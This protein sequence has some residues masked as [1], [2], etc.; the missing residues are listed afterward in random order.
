MCFVSA[1]A[2]LACVA[3]NRIRR[4]MDS[5]CAYSQE[6]HLKFVELDHSMLKKR[7][8]PVP[9]CRSYRNPQ[10]GRGSS[11]RRKRALADEELS[12][13]QSC[14]DAHER[15]LSY[16]NFSKRSP[17]RFAR[18]S[19]G[20]VHIAQPGHPL[21]D[22]K[23]ALRLRPS[24]L[25]LWLA[26][27]TTKITTVT[28]TTTT[29]QQV[30][31]TAARISRWLRRELKSRMA[32]GLPPIVPKKLDFSAYTQTTT[33]APKVL[34]HLSKKGHSTFIPR[35]LNFG[36][37]DCP[38]G[39]GQQDPHG[40]FL[41]SGAADKD[42][43]VQ[44]SEEYY[45]YE[46]STPTRCS[47]I[48]PMKEDESSASSPKRPSYSWHQ[49]KDEVKDENTSAEMARERERG[50]GASRGRG[51]LPVR[52]L[53]R[54]AEGLPAPNKQNAKVARWGHRY[55]VVTTTS[56]VVRSIS[57]LALF[58]FFAGSGIALAALRS[59]SG[60]CRNHQDTYLALW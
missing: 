41:R 48:S 8:K 49:L 33:Y 45:D 31:T 53:K 50:L 51:C 46:S 52:V 58:S 20:K 25:P 28:T 5:R 60:F 30:T 27:A 44:S 23:E 29:T 34:Q 18:F 15:R 24:M 1:L 6:W 3:H 43:R 36:S 42:P 13:S 39:T 22:Y 2:L 26:H 57:V 54:T 56:A 38:D 55:E 16:P 14:S 19:D 7:H 12:A 17:L 4:A 11:L 40:S 47:P 21:D 37:E 35:K 10:C 59:R 32:A 9:S